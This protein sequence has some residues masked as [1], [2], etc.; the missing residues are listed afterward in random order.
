MNPY[1]KYILP[2][3]INVACGMKPITLQRQKVVPEASGRILEVGMGSGLN[4]PYY[5]PS[6]VE[7]V[8]GLEPSEDMRALASKRVANAPF[9]VEFIDLPGEEIPL[10]DNSVDTVL[11]TYTLCTIPDTAQALAQ[12]KRVLKPGGK[13]LFS[14]HGAAPDESVKKWQE[15]INPYWKPIAGGCNLNRAIPQLLEQAGFKIK[16]M[17]MAYLPG[18]PKF[19][20]FNYW[21][22]ATI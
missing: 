7:K 13:L 6:K 17:D 1:E 14:E 22:E 15:R 2:H 16:D 19:A 10:E 8:Y 3:F 12:M 9:E 21:G 20:G 11:L 18:T 4:M 5:D